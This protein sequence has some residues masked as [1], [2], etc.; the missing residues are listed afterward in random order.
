MECSQATGVSVR[1]ILYVCRNNGNWPRDG[2]NFRFLVNAKSWPC[3]TYESLEIFRHSTTGHERHGYYITDTITNT[4]TFYP[5]M[6]HCVDALGNTSAKALVNYVFD[7]TRLFR[8][9]Y[10]FR[11][12]D[13]MKYVS[14]S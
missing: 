1:V 4:E 13:P 10:R 9:R 5:S 11:E 3:F 2:Y 12:Y 14:Y 7:Q 8:K 6:Q